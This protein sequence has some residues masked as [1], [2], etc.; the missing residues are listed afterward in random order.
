[1][2]VPSNAL[3]INSATPLASPPVINIIVVSPSAAVNSAP[4][5][6]PVNNLGTMATNTLANSGLGFAAQLA[7]ALP[8]PP[9]PPQPT[10]Q[11]SFSQL[12]DMIGV[13]TTMNTML[14]SLLSKTQDPATPASTTVAAPA[15][16]AIA[17]AAAPTPA[18]APA[19]RTDLLIPNKTQDATQKARLDTTLAKLTQDPEGAILLAA[20]K[21]A[22]YTIEVGDP[23]LGANNNLIN[24]VTIPD[25]NK[26]IVNP[27]APDFDKTVIHELVHATTEGDDDSQTEE[28]LA[29]VIGFRI[30]ARIN[31]TAEPGTDQQIFNNKI[32]SY[33]TLNKNNAII[34]SLLALGIK[35]PNLSA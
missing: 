34:A 33:P 26:I 10:V 5:P 25:Q 18:A 7:R 15:A 6:S 8:P 11:E 17:A 16:P 30:S 19:V 2:T 23:S 9:P 14:G 29:D 1:M 27:K 4:A 35:A 13:L 21:A 3:G 20:A 22:G 31:G 28:G 32:L 24:G 12:G